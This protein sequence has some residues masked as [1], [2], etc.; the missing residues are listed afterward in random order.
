MKKLVVSQIVPEYAKKSVLTTVPKKLRHSP[1]YSFSNLKTDEKKE[2]LSK[3]SSKWFSVDVKYS[4]DEKAEY[5]SSK[6]K[7]I[8]VLSK[9]R[10]KKHVLF[11]QNSSIKS[12]SGHVACRFDNH[13]SYFRQAPENWSLKSENEYRRMFKSRKLLVLKLI[14]CTRRIEFWWPFRTFPPNVRNIYCL[15]S[16][17]DEKK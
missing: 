1:K 6:F 2:K 11:P 5:S 17:S 10:L 16:K 12:F 13:A 8:S 7:T 3:N 9:K 15:K 4:F 14:H